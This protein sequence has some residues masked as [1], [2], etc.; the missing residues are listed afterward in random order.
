ML[1]FSLCGHTAADMALF[2]VFIQD[3]PNLIIEIPV[4]VG[5]SVLKILMHGRFG[6]TEFLRGSSDGCSGFDHVHSQF[7]SSLIN[8]VRHN[9]PSLVCAT[10]KRLCLKTDE[11]VALT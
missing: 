1:E 9:L 4:T 5:E 6:D 10:K 3:F 8:C 2:F 7:A 11:Y